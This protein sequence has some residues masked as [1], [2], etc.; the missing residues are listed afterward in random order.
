MYKVGLMALRDF[1]LW[2]QCLKS[3]AL[4][5]DELYLRFDM[6]TGDQKILPE[7][8]SCCDGKLRGLI[9]SNIVWNNH[10]WKEE[11]LRCLDSIQHDIVLFPDE[12]EEFGDGIG[13]EIKRFADSDCKE[14]VFGFETILPE[15]ITQAPSK[16]GRIYP[17]HK[18]VKIFKWKPG[19]TYIPYGDRGRLFTYF[20]KKQYRAKTKIIHYHFYTKELYDKW[21]DKLY[22]RFKLEENERMING[23]KRVVYILSSTR[24]G[25]TMLDMVL[26]SHSE[27]VS[28]GEK[29]FYYK[30]AFK[31]FNTKILV[32]SSKKWKWLKER[33]DSESYEY[34]II[35]L[36]RN[37]LDRLKFRKIND[38]HIRPYVVQTWVNTHKKCEKLRKKYGGI[39]VKYEEIEQEIPRICEFIGIDYQP[40]MIE[41]W[42]HE[43]HGLLGSKTAY[44]M[45]RKY[46]NKKYENTY[47]DE[48]G[49]NIAPRLGHEFLDE[50]DL[51]V[52]NKCVGRKL[53]KELGYE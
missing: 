1:P 46:H 13:K 48:H 38:G 35:H 20:K 14:M 33:I 3:L 26:S 41:F 27:C 47:V 2:K 10:N 32:D 15:G 5:V 28:L 37:G 8:E 34:K 4:H 21:K 24:S 7:I 45:V 52:F 25:S 53:N 6:R 12:D 42:K 49:Y 44:S 43:H 19:L 23:R 29:P 40:Q 17:F 9:K 39:L 31:V 51:K 22:N 16:K 18:H 36:V 50:K 30:E 11:L